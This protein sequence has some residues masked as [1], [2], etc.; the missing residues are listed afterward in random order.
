MGGES[1]PTV[2]EVLEGKDRG[3]IP[4]LFVGV[5]LECPVPLALRLELSKAEEARVARGHGIEE[6]DTAGV[7]GDVWQD[8]PNYM[9]HVHLSLS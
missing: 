7:A 8:H 4:H 1:Y 5:E 9:A 2:S 3:L 6:G